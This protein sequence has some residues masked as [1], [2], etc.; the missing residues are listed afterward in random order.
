MLRGIRKR[1]F[2]WF[3]RRCGVG[4]RSVFAPLAARRLTQWIRRLA[5]SGQVVGVTG[6]DHMA[7]AEARPTA[8]CD[9]PDGVGVR[10]QVPLCAR[11]GRSVPSC[12]LMHSGK[13]E[14]FRKREEP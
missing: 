9:L 6:C 7:G 3:L 10:S 13:P 8:C 12:K 11:S 1:L 2:A 4:L 14:E 5:P